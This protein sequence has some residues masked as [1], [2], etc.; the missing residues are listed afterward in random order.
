MVAGRPGRSEALSQSL[1]TVKA[2]VHGE[3]DEGTRA[4]PGRITSHA[5]LQTAEK[6]RI[7]VS[8]TRNP[9]AC[10]TSWGVSGHLTGSLLF[11]APFFPFFFPL[12][13]LLGIKAVLPGVFYRAVQLHVTCVVFS[14]LNICTFKISSQIK[15]NSLP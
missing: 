15:T 9:S 10:P 11:R 12:L 5:T 7:S 8:L 6:R 1:S 3:C 13:T 4:L 2:V 14:L